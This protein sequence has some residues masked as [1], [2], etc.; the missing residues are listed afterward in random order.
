[1]SLPDPRRSKKGSR[2]SPIALSFVP[3]ALYVHSSRV[4]L[5][6]HRS[7]T[8]VI[9]DLAPHDVSILIDWLGEEPNRV[10]AVGRSSQGFGPADVAFVPSLPHGSTGKL[11]R[12]ALQERDI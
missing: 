6:I 1:M 4:N 11:L 9:W 8:S 7:D 12:R 5:G 10:S 3:A 2:P